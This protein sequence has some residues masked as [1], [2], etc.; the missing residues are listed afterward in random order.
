MRVCGTDKVCKQM[1][2]EGI[3]VARCTVERLMKPQ[4]LRGVIRGN[5][6]RTTTPE[7]SAPRPL[8]RVNCQFNADGP[9][10]LWVS[11]FAY[12][13]TWQDSLYVAFVINVFARPIVGWRVSPSMTTD[14]VVDA[15]EKARYARRPDND[16]TLIHHC[17]RGSQHVS[18]GDSERLAQAGIAP[19]VGSRSDS[20]DS[21]LTETINGLYKAE[22]IH[23]RGREKPVSLSN[24]RRWNRWPGST[25]IGRWSRPAISRLRKLGQTLLPATQQYLC[26]AGIDLNLSPPRFTGDGL[27][28]IL[29]FNL[30][31]KFSISIC[32]CGFRFRPGRERT[33][34]S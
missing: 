23:R 15:P 5:R 17:G 16:G 31:L 14:F 4:G 33:A 25:V 20:Y 2:R 32:G 7:V 34:Q 24:W 28:E 6:V 3:T 29:Y 30:Q 11:D 22:L 26:C 18:I 9:N 10:Q 12:V 13:S 27:I 8:D 1:D 19:S 21:T